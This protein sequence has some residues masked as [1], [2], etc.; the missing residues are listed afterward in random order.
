MLNNLL[1]SLLTSTLTSLT[2]TRQHY[3]AFYVELTGVAGGK[4]Q[5]RTWWRERDRCRRSS[6]QI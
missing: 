1:T 5:F 3:Q 6:I 4:V 2:L